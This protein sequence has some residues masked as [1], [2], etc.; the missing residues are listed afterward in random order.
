MAL[1]SNGRPADFLVT[2]PQL[3]E[4]QLSVFILKLCL[5]T[6][7]LK[8]VHLCGYKVEQRQDLTQ[9]PLVAVQSRDHASLNLINNTTTDC[10]LS[11]LRQGSHYQSLCPRLHWGV[12]AAHY[13]FGDGT[14]NWNK[15]EQRRGFVL[16]SKL[17]PCI[18]SQVLSLPTL[19]LL[20]QLQLSKQPASLDCSQSGCPRCFLVQVRAMG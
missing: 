2:S 12:P 14:Y 1:V 11:L 19:V 8:A 9:D 4:E 16:V 6:H 18:S 13:L 7:R 5:C 15:K 10:C 17:L 3:L 20:G